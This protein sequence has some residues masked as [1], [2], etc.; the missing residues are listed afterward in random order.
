MMAR[1]LQAWFML[2]GVLVSRSGAIA[3]APTTQGLGLSPL[4]LSPLGF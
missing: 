2:A 3:S 1:S 4:G